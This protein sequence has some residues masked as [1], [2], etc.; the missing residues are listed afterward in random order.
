MRLRRRTQK[1]VIAVSITINVA[2]TVVPAMRG[3]FDELDCWL[4]GDEVADGVTLPVVEAGVSVVLLGVWDGG[5]AA[6]RLKAAEWPV[7][8][9]AHRKLW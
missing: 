4:R 5:V 2:P 3:V 6:G 7:S 8:I 1:R 9:Q